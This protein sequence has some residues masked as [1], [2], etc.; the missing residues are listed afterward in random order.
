MKRNT[1]KERSMADDEK[2]SGKK[3][4]KQ[5]DTTEGVI[6]AAEISF[7]L[8]ALM[9]LFALR[10]QL[11]LSRAH[12]NS[13]LEMMVEHREDF[14]SVFPSQEDFEG[15]LDDFH[16]VSHYLEALDSEVEE[17]VDTKLTAINAVER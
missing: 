1:Q 15:F 5:E 2:K 9:E 4:E 8:G 12:M 17:I 11:Q 14:A 7:D 16:K 13:V 10:P 3:S 6:E